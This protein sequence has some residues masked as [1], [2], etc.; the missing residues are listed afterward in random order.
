MRAF[1]A[2][3]QL[4]YLSLLWTANA[5]P[6]V[7]SPMVYTPPV[8][9]NVTFKLFTE[10]EELARIVDISYCVGNSGIHKPFICASRCQDFPGFELV[11]VSRPMNTTLRVSEPL[12]LTE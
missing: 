5:L 8:N 1:S 3:K 4:L 7:Q 9:R 6:A 12:R 10:L 11:T 2:V